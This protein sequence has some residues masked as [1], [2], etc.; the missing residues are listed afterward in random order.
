[1]LCPKCNKKL[2]GEFKFCPSC[3]AELDTPII[4]VD[5]DIGTVRGD[6]TGTIL[7]G[8]ATAGGI[9][10][11]TKQKVDTVEDGGT[12]V[13]TILGSDDT[14]VHIGGQQKYGDIVKG[15]KR[16][17]D[18]QGGAYIGGSVDISG[19][20]FVGRDKVVHGGESNAGANKSQRDTILNNLFAPVLEVTQ[21]AP[22]EKRDAAQKKMQALLHEVSNG[23]RADDSNMAELIDDLIGLVPDV[24]SAIVSV[25]SLPV[26]ADIAGPITSFVLKRIDSKKGS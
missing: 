19:G 16:E 17:V 12:V 7:G 13:G 4:K 18:T 11:S 21:S 25:F 9:S 20:D 15:D 10:A 22:L 1:M 6:V 14:N 26:M 2:A 24:A 5:Q 23:N 8:G 3:G